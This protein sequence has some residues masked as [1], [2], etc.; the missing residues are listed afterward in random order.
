MRLALVV[1]EEHARA[2]VHLRD[3]DP[4]GAVDDEGAV[5]RHQRHVAHIDVLLLDVA[6]RARA[7][8]LVDVPDDQ[9][10]GDLQ[11][12]GK[13]DAALL[14]LVDIV[15]RRLELVAHEFELRPLGK[16]PDREDRFEHF[17]QP[18][19]GALFGHAAHLQEMVVRALLDLDQ[20]RHRRDFGDA[21]EALADALFARKGNSHACSSLWPA[22]ADP[23][24][25]CRR[26]QPGAGGST[27]GGNGCAGTAFTQ[28]PANQPGCRARIPP[29]D[30][31]TRRARRIAPRFPVRSRRGDRRRRP[32]SGKARSGPTLF[33]P[34]HPHLQAVFLFSPPLPC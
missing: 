28:R 30:A 19:I 9:A 22:A 17:L 27:P 21:S 5:L 11:R 7:G 18:D 4:L 25:V 26:S 10:Q 15:F 31:K 2:A 33:R 3:D 20:V 23:I 24:S 14:A 8:I 1:V 34:S 12:C 13:S 29:S 16:I 32:P 6:D